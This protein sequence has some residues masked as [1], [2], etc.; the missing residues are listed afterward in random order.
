MTSRFDE[1]LGAC[2][3]EIP[4]GRVATCGA[5]ARALGDVRAARTVASWILDHPD[6]DMAHRV[7]RADGRPV[8]EEAAARLSAEGIPLVQD[9][10]PSARFI[11]A[12]PEVSLLEELR[13]EQ[14][15]L[16]QRVS[17]TALGGT[18]ETL[19]GVD[20]AYAG[21][22]AFAVAVTLDARTLEPTQVAGRE[23]EAEFPY[24]PTYLAFR[25]MPAVESAVHALGPK[26]DVLFVDGHGRLHPAHFGF[27]CFAGVRLGL[28]TIGVAKHPLVGTPV[29]SR[30]QANGAIPLVLDGL[31]RGYAWPPPGSARPI[32][33]SVGHRITLEEALSLVRGATRARSPEPLRLA[34]R[35]SKEM[36]RK[37]IAKRDASEQSA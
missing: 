29:P 16:S 34:D 19:G 5:I 32:Y 22:R 23:C 9:R 27:A 31:V 7:V 25:E 28:P 17:E 12:L 13:K 4:S 26:P 14:R 30:K 20:V 2:L 35:L 8:L 10:V 18:P 3:R 1:A 37:K 11:E 15:L 36:K 33:V 6:V 24:I 21:D